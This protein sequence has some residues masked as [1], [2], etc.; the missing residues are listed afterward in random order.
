MH[1]SEISEITK[2]PDSYSKVSATAKYGIITSESCRFKGVILS[3][4]AEAVSW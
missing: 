3:R 4:Q 2:I 1:P